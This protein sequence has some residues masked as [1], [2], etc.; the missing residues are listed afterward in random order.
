[1]DTSFKG[2]RILITGAA[3]GFGA[4]ARARFS[5]LGAEV[6]GCDLS[7]ADG[8]SQLDVSDAKAMAAFHT[9]AG[10]FDIAINNAGIAPALTSLPNTE[11]ETFDQV[12]AVNLRSV[13]LGMKYQ[14]PPMIAQGS[15]VILNVASAAGLVGAGQMAAYAA[16]KHGVV[17]LTRA[18]ADE[19]A[20][21]GIR[22]NAL[23][24]AFAATPLI[25]DLTQAV[26]PKGLTRRIPMGR[27]ADPSEVVEAMVWLCSPA[28][29]FMT[30]QAI[31]IDGG[32]TAI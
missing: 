7:P 29:S 19:T 8:L 4:G 22:I 25:D 13:F 21:A 18:A 12:M 11:V 16:S 32:L 5:Q 3:S 9:D 14:L 23:C 30:G 17:G 1:M 2:K 6:V 10:P 27:I 26:T 20:R 24:P 15:G 31:A 28:N